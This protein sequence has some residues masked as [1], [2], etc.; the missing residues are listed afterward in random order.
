M[1]PGWRSLEPVAAGALLVTAFAPLGW[2]PLAYILPALLFYRWSEASPASA[3]RQGFLFGLGLFGAGASWVYVSVHE[4]GNMP[5][6]MAA[7]FVFMF[8]CYLAL[9]PAMAGWLQ[10]RLA[11]AGLARLV[12]AAPAAWV[13]FE[14][15]RGWLM[16]GFPW[17]HLGYTQTGSPLMNLAPLTGVYG[18]SYL[19]ALL[20]ALLVVVIRQAAVPRLVAV[21]VLTLTLA[22]SWYAGRLEFVKP[23]GEMFRVALVQ[24]NI[25]LSEKWRPGAVLPISHIY[26]DLSHA[27]VEQSSLIVWP[28]GAI[29][30]SWQQNE[31]IVMQRLP[32]RKDGSRPDYLLGSIDMSPGQDYYNA[33]IG[34]SDT[35]SI[36]R[37]QH[38][39]PFGEFLPFSPL[40]GWLINY[41]HIPMSDFSAWQQPQE[42]PILAGHPAGVNI[43]YEDAFG[44][45]IIAAARTSSYLVNLSED[46]W[47]GDSL[48]LPQRLQMAR[49]RARETGR[50][51]LRAANTGITAVITPDGEISAR[52]EP[53]QRAVLTASVVPMS[54]LTPYVRFGNMPVLLLLTASLLLAVMSGRRQRARES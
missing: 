36:Y 4:F 32:T 54:G 29:P 37:K 21:S 23:A 13:L 41:L 15:L 2:F 52:L 25:P 3:A 10:A 53:F 26:R 50:S 33:A 31:Q 49:V 30:E 22:V 28:E 19:T 17:L 18:M 24:A 42:A 43:C 1:R 44:E 46:A 48:A 6:P 14:W 20:A 35:V 8:I 39:V 16:T 38:L 27:V 12:F 5:A 7:F 51:F 11:P 47:F 45:E 9:F 40:L 34:L